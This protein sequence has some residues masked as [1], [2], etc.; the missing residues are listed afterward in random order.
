MI[1]DGMLLEYKNGKFYEILSDDY[2]V[3]SPIDI[4]IYHPQ[5]FLIED[6]TPNNHDDLYLFYGRRG[7]PYIGQWV[8]GNKFV[9]TIGHIEVNAIAWSEIY[10]PPEIIFKK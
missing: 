4:N 6:K 10:Y 2:F 3:G 1:K 7:T 5:V 8:I 9:T